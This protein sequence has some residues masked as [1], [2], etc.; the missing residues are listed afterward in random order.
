MGSSSADDT[1][2]GER[3]IQIRLK[4]V[5]PEYSVPDTIL[6][7]PVSVD[8]GA[9]NS[10]VKSLVDR[11]PVPLFDFIIAEDLLRTDLAGFLAIHDEISP[12]V[13]L[14]ILYIEQ[15]TPPKPKKNVS[16]DDWVAGVAA[17]GNFVVSG[18]YDN[19]VTLWSNPL[20]QDES[21]SGTKLATIPSHAGPVR[22]VAW[23]DLD[24][25]FGTFAST[26]HDQILMLHK[27]NH[28]SQKVEVM[29]A[30][31]GHKRSVDC[32]AVDPTKNQ[33]ASGSYDGQLKIWSAKISTTVDQNGADEDDEVSEQ[34]KSKIDGLTCGKPLTRTPLVTL[35][36]HK[37]GVSG[38]TWLDHSH[39]VCTS[40]LD[41]TVK[42][43]DTENGGMKSELVGNKA[44][45]GL[46]YSNQN[47]LL[48]TAACER[49]IRAYDPRST[50]G[51][52]VKS[53]YASHQGWIT[54][55]D[56]CG[57]IEHPNLFVSGS[58]DSL[59]K[60]WDIRSYR[61]PLYD[62]TGHTDRVMCCNW[63][64]PD[65]IV[66]GGTDNDMKIFSSQPKKN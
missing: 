30:C 55:V 23:I 46:S 29:N 54:C 40:S 13:V 1:S 33:I 24:D 22:A 16:H 47:R 7:V 34:K 37:E 39:E 3:Q 49:T 50:E 43:W 21:A 15:Q 19:T 9:L 65:F 20:G 53:A 64:E 63:S 31:K 45:F 44:F 26:S 5:H 58:H 57:G 28:K 51:L 8:Q 36:G 66:S 60:M 11:D 25:E 56:W 10:L 6:S 59:V 17:M 4:T 62:L 2:G 38:V 27:W 48:L 32:V 14:D 35:V 18:C 61:T 12:E 42:I 52:L 41:H